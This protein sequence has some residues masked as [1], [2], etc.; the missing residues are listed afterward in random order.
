MAKQDPSWY[1]RYSRN[2]IATSMKW[3]AICNPNHAGWALNIGGNFPWQPIQLQY[4]VWC[5]I[6]IYQF[7]WEEFQFFAWYLLCVF[8]FAIEAKRSKQFYFCIKC[9]RAVKQVTP[10]VC[11]ARDRANDYVAY[12]HTTVNQNI[13]HTIFVL[14]FF[15]IWFDFPSKCTD[16]LQL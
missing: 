16:T 8:T 5:R 10:T 11:S 15:G 14:D 3:Y 7:N 1:D 4:N 2:H 13:R 6:Q 9:A 12:S